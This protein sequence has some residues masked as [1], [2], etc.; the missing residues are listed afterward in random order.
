MF[1]SKIRGFIWNEL[2]MSSFTIDK[3]A[4][5]RL[6]G[7]ITMTCRRK[8]D[9]LILKISSYECAA[10]STEEKCLKRSAWT[11]PSED[12]IAP[13]LDFPRCDDELIL[14]RP[15]SPSI[16]SIDGRLQTRSRRD[17]HSPRHDY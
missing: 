13:H 7:A 1:A 17:H 11:Y 8:R 5:S 14:T 16:P 15:F 3:A 12:A 9:S 6:L 2:V 10:S 4:M